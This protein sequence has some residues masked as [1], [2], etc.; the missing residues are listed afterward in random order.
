MTVPSHDTGEVWGKKDKK[1]KRKDNVDVSQAISPQVTSKT[2]SAPKS[3][4]KRKGDA[5]GDTIQTPKKAKDSVELCKS[6]KSEGTPQKT[7]EQASQKK[8]TNL[9]KK[10]KQ[11]QKKKKKDVDSEEEEEAETSEKMEEKKSQK[12]A[13]QE[14][15]K[16][17]LDYLRLWENDRSNWRFQKIRQVWLLQNMYNSKKVPDKEFDIL[18]KYLEKLE[19]KAKVLTV[20]KSEELMETLTAEMEKKENQDGEG[21]EEEDEETKSKRY[22]EVKK[23]K[24]QWNRAK[25]I[26]QILT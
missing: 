16:L 4:K 14:N 19:G 18:L 24:K 5:K 7:T 23:M 25:Q 9:K 11:M 22:Y 10:K 12:V 3:G 20:Q 17:A 1:K 21:E 13:P 8:R 26:L 2:D 6:T 15:M